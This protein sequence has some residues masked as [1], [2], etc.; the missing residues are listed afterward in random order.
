M[1][2]SVLALDLSAKSTGWA[3]AALGT[4][5]AGMALEGQREDGRRIWSG[6]KSFRN[7]ATRRAEGKRLGPTGVRFM[8]WLRDLTLL[9][10]VKVI[11][12]E[13]PLRPTV[14]RREHE[15]ENAPRLQLGL[16]FV[17]EVVAAQRGIT[18]VYEVSIQT[19]KKFGAGSGNASKAAMRAMAEQL[20]GRK[21]GSDDEADA[22]H[23]LDFAL[24]QLRRR[25]RGMVA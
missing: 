21:V 4:P 10:E 5:P 6:A 15:H 2:A 11:Y 12:V 25:E 17:T 16:A 19:L 18:E 23:L 20:Y 24:H 9:H 3:I 13:A 7:D 1:P 22:L 14:K 8:V